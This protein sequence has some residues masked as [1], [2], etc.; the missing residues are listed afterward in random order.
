MNPS[1]RSRTLAVLVLLT[2]LGSVVSCGGDDA[3]VSVA[4]GVDDVESSVHSSAESRE[5]L[6]AGEATVP[7]ETETE[8]VDG[9]G[10]VD[11]S[12]DLSLETSAESRE[13][14]DADEAAVLAEI[15]AELDEAIAELEAMDP[16]VAADL[17]SAPID[18]GGALDFGVMP[19][20]TAYAHFEGVGPAGGMFEGGISGDIE[21]G[22]VELAEGVWQISF[23][24]RGNTDESGAAPAFSVSAIG[25]DYI[26]TMIHGEIDSG[27]LTYAMT[28][29]ITD[30]DN[31]PGP[32]EFEV[33]VTA[34]TSWELFIHPL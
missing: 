32:F 34:E 19:V 16:D 1:I 31:P 3:S 6:D 4:D 5:E 29:G 27:E 23:A 28:V 26:E 20:E 7:A 15:E 18:T 2:L 33:W 8:S 17:A 13:E 25:S 14:L 11:G 9:V 21:T 22:P 30:Q 12:V 10:D 24:F